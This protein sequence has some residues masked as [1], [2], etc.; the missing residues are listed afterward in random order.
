MDPNTLRSMLGLARVE[1]ENHHERRV[2]IH[3]REIADAA[4]RGYLVTCRV[5]VRMSAEQHATYAHKT[6]R[7]LLEE[8]AR[9]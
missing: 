7:H 2:P 5:P 4:V 8:D 9:R 1:L 3:Y 6:V